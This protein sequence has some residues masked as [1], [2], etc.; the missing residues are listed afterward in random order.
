MK[1]IDL[2]DLPLWSQWPARLLGLSSW[3]VPTR[4]IEKIEAEY[5][6]DKWAQR[7]DFYKSMGGSVTPADIETA[8]LES[9]PSAEK[10]CVSVGDELYETNILDAR[11]AYDALI[12]EAIV[13]F[14]EECETVVELGAGYG[15]NLWLLNQHL[16]GH[17]FVGGEYASN[18]VY[19]AS[20]LFQDQSGIS[21]RQFDFYDPETY[22]F[23]KTI[24]APVVIFTV[25]AIEQ[26]PRASVVFDTL[27]TY[28][29]RI[30][31][32]IHIE[33]IYHQEDKSLLGLMRRR[34]IEINDYNRDLLDQ[35]QE[36]PEIRI[37]R[38]E[39]NVLSLVP[40]N[41]IGII[42]WKFV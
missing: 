30:S 27:L 24:P 37:V 35:L 9:L 8:S 34:Y 33:P 10:W 28:R 32:V 5:N 2:N 4:T 15:Y 42:Q 41:S 16:R 18:A 19:L 40:L 6:Q 23:L 13:P 11:K 14:V 25:Q 17:V 39:L 21:V 1:R 38:K 22:T 3:I 36:R 26:L 20:L 12:R 7:L 29:D 31:S